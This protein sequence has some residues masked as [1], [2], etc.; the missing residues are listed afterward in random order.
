MKELRHRAE[1]PLVILGLV[2]TAVVA[3]LAIAMLAN[4]DTPDEWAMGSC[5]DS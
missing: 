2:L 4:G 5:W 1:W 3:A